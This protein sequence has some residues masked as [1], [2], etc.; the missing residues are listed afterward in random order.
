MASFNP[1]ANFN[2]QPGNNFPNPNVPF[3]QGPFFQPHFEEIDEVGQKFYQE[4]EQYTSEILRRELSEEERERF[5]IAL[6]SIFRNL[7]SSELSDLQTFSIS[8]WQV[9]PNPMAYST[10]KNIKHSHKYK[11]KKI[12]KYKKAE[13]TEEEKTET[14]TEEKVDKKSEGKKQKGGKPQ[15]IGR[16]E[17]Y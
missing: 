4:L 7:T 3:M 12:S 8:R 9:N 16:F 10:R 15:I 2:S 11:S 17:L 6:T 13:T 14:K 5:S 1:M